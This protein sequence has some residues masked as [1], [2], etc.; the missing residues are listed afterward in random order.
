MSRVCIGTC[1]G[2][3]DAALVRA[4]FSAH[5]IP[6]VIGAEQHANMLGGLGGSFLSLDILVDEADAE[7]AA[8]LLRDLRDSEAGAGGEPEDADDDHTDA[9]ADADE[10]DADEPDD[11]EPD[12]LPIEARLDRRR[13]T[14]IALLLAC[15][16]TFGTGHM[17]TR[18]WLRGFLLLGLELFAFSRLA[19]AP[20]EGA[21]LCVAVVLTDA[22]GA[23]VRVRRSARGRLPRA[24]LAHR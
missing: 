21:I 19:V 14:G 1:A 24:Q 2:P 22:I 12:A 3:A 9:D 4:M 8:A 10:P 5:D 7:E 18:A 15:C 20:L 6:V 11:G 13:R 23:V 17:F 16:V